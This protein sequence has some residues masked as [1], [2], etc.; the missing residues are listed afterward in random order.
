[1]QG[2]NTLW[3]PE[4]IVEIEVNGRPEIGDNVNVSNEFV[5]RLKSAMF[6]VSIE[7]DTTSGSELTYDVGYRLKG[8][9]EWLNEYISDISFNEDTGDLEFNFNPDAEAVVGEYEFFVGVTDEMGGVSDY[10]VM[11]QGITVQNN[12]PEISTTVDA[13]GDGEPDEVVPGENLIFEKGAYELGLSIDTADQDGDIANVTWYA[14]G[15]ILG[16]GEN[17]DNL[18]YAVLQAGKPGGAGVENEITVV[19]TD[20]DGDVSSDTFIIE[21][22]TAPVE[23]SLVVQAI[24]FATDPDKLPL[25]AGIGL[26]VVLVVGTI[27]LRR[28]SSSTIVEDVIVDDGVSETP[29]VEHEV[30]EWEIPTDAQGNALIIV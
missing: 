19:V 13:D 15:E 7:D 2:T 17:P 21:V 3:S 28:R 24:T 5:D 18:D 11:N 12:V 23:D 9:E 6:K 22:T 26:A 27:A 30:E 20:N 10:Y 14:N 4:Q 8:D 29:Q 25:M 1:M 16:Y